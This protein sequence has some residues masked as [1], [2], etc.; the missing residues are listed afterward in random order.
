MALS[1][2]RSTS[3]A[4]CALPVCSQQVGVLYGPIVLTWML[5]IGITGAISIHKN[6][7]GSVFESWNPVWMRRFWAESQFRGQAAWQAYGGI[8]LSV[9]GAEAL[10]A[11]LGHFGL[12]AIATGWF[13]VVYPLLLLCYTGQ[14]RPWLS[15]HLGFW[16]VLVSALTSALRCTLG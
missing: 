11:D 13:L 2:H 14:A 16:C 3:Q 1:P 12:P 9:T 4:L 15:S 10:F 7:G 5:F 8:F 6:G